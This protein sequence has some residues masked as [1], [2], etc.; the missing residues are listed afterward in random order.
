MKP[1]KLIISA[2]GPY[3]DRTEIDFGSLGGHGLYLITGDTGAGKTTIF[4]AIAFALYGEAS[5][6]VR[7][8]DMFRSKY[9][10]EGVPT[11]VE[12]TF[13]YRGKEYTVKRNPEYMRPKGRGTGYTLQRADA[14]LTYPDGRA[15][16]TK[17]TDVTKAVTEL[18]GLDRRQF[19]QIA[20]IA[21]GDFQRLL[22]AG[23]EERGDIF[24]QIFGTGIYQ[25]IQEQLK[26]DVKLQKEK[27]DE[28][29]RSTS[30]YMD[31]IVCQDSPAGGAGSRLWK[32]REAKFDGRVEEGLELLAKLCGEDQAALEAMD[33]QIEELD[34]EI[35][36]IDQQIVN[37][38]HRE[39]WQRE[40]QENEKRQELLQ[41]ELADREALFEQAR[42]GR[43]ECAT[44]EV[45]IQAAGK[46]LEKFQSLDAWRRAWHA[47]EQEIAG[48]KR[49]REEIIGKSQALEAALAQE[50]EKYRTLAG[51]GEVKERL[52]RRTSALLDCRQSLKRQSESLEQEMD[53]QKT[54]E[55]SIA[56]NHKKQQELAAEI[57]RIQ[58][59][60]E[61]FGNRD[62]MLSA[63]EQMR[64]TLLGQQELLRK[65]EKERDALAGE[66]ERVSLELESASGRSQAL[67]RE[68]E[69]FEKEHAALK[70][71]REAILTCR[72][73]SQEAGERLRVCL[74]QREALEETERALG[75]MEK[76]YEEACA[77]WEAH[78]KEQNRCQVQR[79]ALGETGTRSLLVKQRQEKLREAGAAWEKL[80]GAVEDFGKLQREA[81]SAR[82]RYLAAAEEKQR[83]GDVYRKMD[84]AFLDA[85]AGLLAR[86]L[87][88]GEACPVCGSLHH[89]APAQ[90]PEAVPGKAELDRCKEQLHAA[91]AR[92][93]GLSEKAGYLKEQLSTQMGQIQDMALGL[94]RME[95][96]GEQEDG[97]T[98]L[99]V[100]LEKTADKLNA[101]ERMSEKEAEE[102]EYACQRKAELDELLGAMEQTGKSLDQKRQD[103]LLELNG[104]RSRFS[105]KQGQ[106][107]K[108][109]EGLPESSLR[110]DGLQ[111]RGP[112]ESSMSNLDFPGSA[113]SRR[114]WPKDK[115]SACLQQAYERS[116][117][118][119][120]R[121]KEAGKRLETL[122]KR[123]T[124]AQEQRRRLEAETAKS[125]EQLANLQGRR[126]AAEIQLSAQIEKTG[127]SLKEA[128]RLFEAYGEEG[129]A[130]PGSEMCGS[131]VSC[132]GEAALCRKQAEVC[133]GAL[134][135]WK[136]RIQADIEIREQLEAVRRQWEED[137]SQIQALLGELEKELAGITSRKAEKSVQLWDTLTA[138]TLKEAGRIPDD[139]GLSQD[140]RPEESKLRE[141]ALEA[142]ERLEGM[143]LLAQED[144]RK[145]QADLEQ[146]QELEQSIPRREAEKNRLGEEIRQADLNLAGKAAENAERKKQIEALAEELGD[147]AREQ[148]LEDISALQSKKASLEEI[149]QSA[150]HSLTQCRTG[151]E[152]LAAAIDALHRQIAAAGEESLHSE[153]EA[154]AWRG[155]RLRA[156]RELGE[157]RDRKYTALARNRDILGQVRSKR[158]E[159][160][161]V[162]KKYV[163]MRS[164]A[165]TACGN[166]SGKSKIELETY[167]QMTY[168]D[169]IIRRANLRLLTMSSGQYELKRQQEGGSRSKKAGLE[170]E[171]IDHY[172]ATQRSVK[173][174]SGGESFQASLSLALGLA[175]EIQSH[176][177]GIQ[178]D[179]L[180]VDEGF[181]SLDGEALGQAMRALE[182]LTEGNRLVGI[183]SHVAELKERIDRKIV[184]TK[185]RD[186]DGVGSRVSVQP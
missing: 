185:Y 114:E 48:E 71:S 110:D 37:I 131:D 141:L 165:D 126:E 46:R 90:A 13:A 89:P 5:G 102:A 81:S 26:A 135:E 96:L 128:G 32:L 97:Q 176:A 103:A 177:G 95:V 52:E 112:M 94:L 62:A 19:T 74:E 182:Q 157:K 20:M 156:K 3:A 166:L 154:A 109:L 140:A 136:A 129:N 7:Q 104:A 119:L 65:Q 92:A 167:V 43:E 170:L 171:V 168:F 72:H 39:A 106:W 91:E 55:Q 22:F 163:W 82:E 53:R 186:R 76:A 155:E 132:P 16:V 121:A 54:T 98:D 51:A 10:K 183:I 144:M 117:E 56:G 139:S 179:S 184:V 63:V 57:I 12:Y 36:K 160:A 146:R 69:A 84:Q 147:A 21:Q 108:F 41:A 138:Q 27:Y 38:R 40:L 113:Q 44:L 180:F 93:A 77:R 148:T 175:D 159:I 127:E 31:G 145:N 116:T 152:R 18:I 125:R 25:C 50:Q 58:S 14:E 42:Q 60:G 122:E 172:N 150:E 79:E 64:E 181:G 70:D 67:D 153:E 83:L 134:T 49:R 2:F 59:K 169:R 78:Q 24:R 15:P 9:A 173:T 75:V 142:L 28:L 178:M 120:D 6:Y 161:A 164:L 85:Q 23:T 30:Q 88:K 162:E 80:N 151:S 47:G 124:Q 115:I 158:S 105:E 99:R 11:F 61:A 1:V 107:E 34:E 143:L 66:A 35:R 118:S 101:L 130:A 45:R 73:E 4:D 100:L 33:R 17:V 133:L 87:K 149:Y 111:E 86:G 123:M 174:L 137:L 8:S 29:K 68:K